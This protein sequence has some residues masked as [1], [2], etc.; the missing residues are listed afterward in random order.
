MWENCV[1]G[2]PRGER[3]LFV[4]NQDMRQECR[5]DPVYPSVF[6]LSSALFGAG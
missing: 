5:Q 4:G 6:L 3:V 2:V 1:T